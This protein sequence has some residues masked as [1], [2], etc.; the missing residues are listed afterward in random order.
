M[1]KHL[2]SIVIDSLPKQKKDELLRFLMNEI[3]QGRVFLKNKEQDIKL[4]GFFGKMRAYK[5]AAIANGVSG[6]SKLEVTFPSLVL[7]LAQT[8]KNGQEQWKAEKRDIPGWGK[9]EGCFYVTDIKDN[10]VMG[11]MARKIIKGE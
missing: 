7:L 4:K 3:F 11:I 6:F 2:T 10:A 9:G 8:V 1:E 5:K